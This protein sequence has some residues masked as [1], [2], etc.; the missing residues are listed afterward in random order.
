LDPSVVIQQS[1]I[2]SIHAK[3]QRK[4]KQRYSPSDKS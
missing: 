1:T 3:R 2:S 4:P